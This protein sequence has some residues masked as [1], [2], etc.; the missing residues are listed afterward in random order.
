[1][2]NHRLHHHRETWLLEL[3]LEMK[4]AQEKG[5]PP[6]RVVQILRPVTVH[7]SWGMPLKAP[8]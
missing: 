1:V 7:P 3:Y 8:A 6:A 2:V 4:K 5:N